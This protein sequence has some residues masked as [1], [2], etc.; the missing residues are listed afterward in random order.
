MSSHFLEPWFSLGF[1]RCLG[2]L[3]R[4]LS[5]LSGLFRVPYVLFLSEESNH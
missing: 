2:R 1:F 4:G 3:S 5:S